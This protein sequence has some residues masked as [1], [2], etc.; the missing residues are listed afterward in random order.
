MVSHTKSASLSSTLNTR[1]SKR[2]KTS[3]PTQ[4]TLPP[5][6]PPRPPKVA[7][8]AQ[9]SKAKGKSKANLP[10]AAQA[11]APAGKKRVL[12]VRQGHIDILDGEISLLSTPQRLDSTSISPP[13]T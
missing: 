4:P 7:A 1:S 13:L 10:P 8:A 5:F 12:P 11:A 6:I 3:H 9:P 2:L